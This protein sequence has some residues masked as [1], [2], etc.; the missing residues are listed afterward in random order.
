MAGSFGGDLTRAATASQ[1]C[2]GGVG[3][4]EDDWLAEWETDVPP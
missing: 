3:V 2:E 4:V 1:N